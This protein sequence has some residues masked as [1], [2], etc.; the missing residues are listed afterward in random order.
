MVFVQKV[1]TRLEYRDTTSGLFPLLLLILFT[2]VEAEVIP[3]NITSHLRKH[4][5][6]CPTSA[7]KVS[8]V[9]VNSQQNHATSCSQLHLMKHD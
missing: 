4:I 1:H 5:Q 3:I 7:K 6:Q 2:I 9:P 8:S